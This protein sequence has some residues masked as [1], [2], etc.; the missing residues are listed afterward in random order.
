MI[1]SSIKKH[2]SR[3]IHPRRGGTKSSAVNL[4]FSM[5]TST[6]AGVELRYVPEQLEQDR[7]IHPRRGGTPFRIMVDGRRTETSTHAGVEPD[8][9]AGSFISMRNI[10]PR[11]G[12]TS[13]NYDI[14]ADIWKHPPTQGWNDSVEVL[15]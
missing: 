10:H 9:S 12:G 4:S 11:R 1:A 5:E 3:N 7:N 6:H 14:L 2:E 8:A 15:R 13:G